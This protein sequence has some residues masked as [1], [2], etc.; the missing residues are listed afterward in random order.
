MRA[1]LLRKSIMLRRSASLTLVTSGEDEFSPKQQIA[2]FR[3]AKASKL[4]VEATLV[5]EQLFKF[6]VSKCTNLMSN[7]TSENFEYIRIAVNKSIIVWKLGDI[8]KKKID[9][10]LVEGGELFSFGEFVAHKHLC[11]CPHVMKCS[12]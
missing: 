3:V 7:D 12:K 1:C 2:M 10:V 8:Y 11:W 9:K 5:R 6:L 4:K